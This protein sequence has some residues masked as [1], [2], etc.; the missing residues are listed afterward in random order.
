LDPFGGIGHEIGE[1]LSKLSGGVP[2][3]LAAASGVT[4]TTIMI[5]ATFLRRVWLPV[6][7]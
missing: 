5:L 3:A 4:T 2:P 7:A 6:R 1:T